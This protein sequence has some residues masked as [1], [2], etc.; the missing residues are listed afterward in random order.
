MDS[1]ELEKTI[2]ALKQIVKAN[3]IEIAQLK[4][5]VRDLKYD[6]NLALRRSRY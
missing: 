3:S 2:N 6:V 5:T 4:Q 1:E